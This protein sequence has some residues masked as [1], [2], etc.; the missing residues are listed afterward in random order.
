MENLQRH[1]ILT[2]TKVTGNAKN[3]I[4]DWKQESLKIVMTKQLSK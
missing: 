4:K 2:Y 3:A 1:M